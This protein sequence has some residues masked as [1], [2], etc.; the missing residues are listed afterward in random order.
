MDSDTS[1]SSFVGAVLLGFSLC[2]ILVL[3]HSAEKY[4][5]KWKRRKERTA[6]WSFSLTLRRQGFRLGGCCA[7][8]LSQS[9]RLRHHIGCFRQ[10]HDVAWLRR[11]D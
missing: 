8:A 9:D 3:T 10:W 1:L 6:V 7:N 11:C 5:R 2:A 4:R